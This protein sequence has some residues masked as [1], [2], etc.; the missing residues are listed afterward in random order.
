MR[1]LSINIATP[2]TI[3]VRGSEVATG[4]FK[5]PVEGPRWLGV[6]GLEG[7]VRIEPR[8][9]GEVHH[10]ICAYPSEHYAYWE[11]SLGI[12]RLPPG[13]FGENLTLAGLVE[14]QVRVGEVWRC[15]SALLQVAQPRI[16]CR[17]L[18]AR[19]GRGFSRLF[20]ET[21]R[22]GFY[23]RVLEPGHA[24]AGDPLEPVEAAPA[25]P[26]IDEFVRI[27]QVDDWDVQGLDH[28][29]R[30]RDL[31]PGWREILE[32]KRVRAQ[33]ADGWFGLRELEVT[34]R[35]EHSPSVVS[36]WLRCARGLPL[37]P[38][39]PGQYLTVAVRP[40]PDTVTFRRAY[41]ISSPSADTSRYR[42]TVR[43]QGSVC[44]DQDAGVVSGYIH[45]HL[46]PGDTLQA[47][48]PRGFF[49]L[50]G[51]PGDR[52]AVVFL[53]QGIGIA[54]V[55]SM[56]HDWARTRSPGRA[57][58]LAW[59]DGSEPPLRNEVLELA[60]AH[61][62]LAVR[63]IPGGA[64]DV[65]PDVARILE[66]APGSRVEAFVSGSTRFVANVSSVLRDLGIPAGN[67]H[68]ERFGSC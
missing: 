59:G 52:D 38:F 51:L 20:L 4:L 58:L 35:Q 31:V 40:S 24:R 21:R 26:T 14:S 22:V 10:A 19:M 36:L 29:L 7:D 32:A 2:R 15:G 56:L 5:A 39:S 68:E 8:K 3:E 12:S 6:E 43:R 55:V 65:R 50:D 45:R 23:L 37:A 60:R 25:S 16:P 46:H 64:G 67:L 28:L 17:K 54:P 63:F 1:I 61:E 9:L 62:G 42:I 27:S 48:A 13:T 30:A 34:D 57:A 66:R 53:T 47:A 11:E 33:Q 41:A 49:T 18:E 44:G